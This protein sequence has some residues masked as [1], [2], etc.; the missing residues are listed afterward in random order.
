MLTRPLVSASVWLVSA[1]GSA[2]L[3]VIESIAKS[4][5]FSYPAS[6]I[7]GVSNADHP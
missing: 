6:E 1:A 4:K 2:A 5:C 3:A 7:L